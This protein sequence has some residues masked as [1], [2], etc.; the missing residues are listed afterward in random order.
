MNK[1]HKILLFLSFAI[2]FGTA[3]AVV[4]IAPSSPD[5]Q[6]SPQDEA[7]EAE[8]REPSF[9]V[10]NNKL[11]TYE[12]LGQT[13]SMDL[14]DPE[15]IKE[16]I[17]FDPLTNT[18]FFKTKVGN[19]DVVTPY[20]MTRDEYMDFSMK[21]SMRSYWAERNRA[22]TEND[23]KKE[24]SISD[25]KFNIGAADKIFGPGGV[26]VK[27]QG[28]TELLFGFKVN[29]IQNPTLSE[30][31]RNPSPIFDFDEKIQLNVNGKV[32]DKLNFTMN[33]NTEASF[34]YDQSK[35]KLAYEGK[36]DDIVQRV[37]AGNVSLPLN[38]ALIRG[39]SALF[40]IKTEL[41]FGK[42][43]VAAV[44]S[45]QETETKTVSL[46][47][48]AQTSKFELDA[49]QY[50]ENRH[51]FLGHYFKDN[52][53]K[54]MSRLPN[55]NSGI[56]VNRIEVWITNK[57]ADFT[58]ARNIV[59][60]MDLGEVSPNIDNTNLWTGTAG[61]LLPY[62]KAN[63]LYRD[64]TSL[65]NVRD[66]QQVNTV[67]ES[68]FPSVSTGFAGGEDFEKVES[69]RLLNPNEFTLNAQLGYLS[70]KSQLNTD[71][72]L[73]VAYEYTANGKVYQVGE[74]SSDGIE[75]PNAL[76]LKMLKGTAFSPSEKNWSLMMK[77]VYSLGA[78]QIQSE[79]FKLDV[80]FQN[81]STGAYVNYMPEGAMRNQSLL[82]V[83]KLD[84]LDRRNQLRP[85][86]FFDY[87]DGFTIIPL[88]GRIIFPVLE[89]FGSSLRKS[90]GNDVI[91]QKYIFQE[92]YDSTKIVAEELSEKNKFVLRG[93]Y[94]ASVN[95]EIRLNAM[96]VPQGSVTVL[97]GGV[98]L[99]E[100]IDYTV[101]YSMG[102]VTILNQ[103]IL[104]SGT[105]IDVSLESQ[106]F[107]SMQR[108]T[109]TGV[110][111]EYQFNKNFS[112]GGTFMH[113]SEKPLTNKVAFGDE[114]MSNTI[115]GLNTDF[116][117]ES[118]FITNLV[119]KI[120][121]IKATAPSSY[122]LS[123]E[124]AQLIP[125]HPNVIGSEGLSYLDDFEAS[126]TSINIQYP[127]AWY[128]ASTPKKPTMFPEATQT[129]NVDYGKNRALISWFTIDPLF[130]TNTST[131][132]SH[133]R[134]DKE[135]LSNHFVRS[136]EEQE[137]FPNREP[138]Q[139]QS[140]TLSVLNL[141]YYPTQRGPYN[142]DADNINPDGSLK[143]PEKRWAGIMRKMEVA[144][145]ESANIEY[146]EF[147]ML[148]PFVYDKNAKG[149]DLYLNLGEI[150]EDVL[151]DGKK[152]F[153]NGLAA[154]GDTTQTTRTVWGRVP[155]TQSM[156]NAF[157]NE[158][159]A[160]QYQDVGMDGLRT[161]DE[162]SFSSYKNYLD[163]F[164]LKV[165]PGKLDSLQNDPFSPIN[166]P[167]GDNYRYYRGSDADNQNM[168]ILD[169]YK[170]YNGQE[171]NSPVTTSTSESYTT[172]ATNLPNL[173]DIN[174]DNNLNEYE[175]FWEYRV[176]IKP[177]D[178]VVGKNYISDKVVSNV[179]LE[180]GNYEEVAWYQF[181]VPVHEYES[182]FGM[183]D[184]RSIRFMRMYM[185][186]FE[187]TTNLRFGTMELVRGDWRK[188]KKPLY[189]PLSPPAVD[190]TLEVAVVNIEENADK[191]PVNYVLP[192]GVEREQDPSQSQIRQE[193]EQS[194]LLKVTNLAPK[195][196][197]GVYKTTTYDMRQFKR[198][199]MYV[200]AEEF[201]DDVT[202][203]E[204]SELT[205]FVRVGSDLT[206]NYYEY[207]IPLKLTSPGVYSETESSGDREKVWPSEN[208][209][210][211]NLESL[212]NVKSNR[213]KE[214]R[215]SGS[216]I[217][218]T[219]AYSEY[220]PD[221]PRNKITVVGNPNL[222]DV[223][224]IMVGVRN[225]SSQPKSGEIWVNELR[226]SGFNEE[227]GYAALANATVNLS[228][229][230]SVNVGGRVETIGFGGIEDNVMERRM[231]D[232][233]QFNVSTNFELGRFFPE[234]AK[235]RI[236]MYYSYSQEV[237]KPKYDAF[238]QDILLSKTLEDA[239]TK[240]EE[241]SISD[242]SNTVYTTRS[243]NF[244][245]VRV[246]LKSKTPM[247]YDP[248][249][250]SLN[251]SYTESYLHSPE[252]ER[253]V[254]KDYKAGINYIYT[255]SPRPW[256]PFKNNK[257]L[258]KPTMR[259]I[260][261]F[262][263]F[264]LPVSIA[265]STSMMRQYNEKQLRNLD[266]P[267][268][269]YTDPN[270]PLLSNSKDFLWNRKF[271]FKYDFSRALKFSYSNSINSQI[272]ESRYAPVNKELFPD[273]YQNW[274]D[275]VLRSIGNGGV[276]LA[277]QQMVTGSYA[278]PIN[279]IPALSWINSNVMY[280]GNYTWDRGALTAEDDEIG[281][282]T[283][284]LGNNI[285][286][287]G[288]WQFD[289]R[290]SLDQLY[291]KSSYL[292][293]VNKRFDTKRTSKKETETSVKKKVDLFEQKVKLVKGKSQKLS[294]RL[295]V[296]KIRLFAFDSVGNEYK[297]KYTS[298]DKNTIEINP[299]DGKEITV[300]IQALYP[301]EAT[302]FEYALQ[303]S[304]RVLMMIRNLSFNYNQSNGMALAGFIPASGPLGQDALGSG[305]APGL[306]FAMG[307]Q[308]PG[309][310]ETAY[311]KDWLLKSDSTISG[312]NKTFTS[313]LSIK[314]KVEPFAGLKIDF[315]VQRSYATQQ[316][317][318]YMYAGMPSTM[319]GSFSMT[320]IGIGTFFNSIGNSSNNYYSKSYESFKSNR[321][322]TQ[323]LLESRYAGRL[324]PKVGFMTSA[325][326]SLWAGQEYNSS[327]VGGFSQ[328]SAEVLVPSFLS[329]YTG[330]DLNSNNLDLIPSLL[331][332]LPN[333]RITYDGLSRISF[334]QDYVKSVNLTHAYTC[335]YNVGAFSSYGNWIAMDGGFGF[336]EDVSSGLP[337]PSSQFDVPAVSITENFNP[338]LRVDVTLKNNI[339]L[340]TEYSKGRVLGLNIASTQ[341]VE[342]G[343]DTY[344]VGA[345]Y[346]LSD[347]DVILRLSNDKESK[348]KNDLTLRADFSW[349]DTK[350]LIRKLDDD[351]ATQATSGDKT[352]GVQCSAEYVF[353]SKMNFRLYYDR[354]VSTPLI[355]SS[356]PTSSSSFGL[357]V[358]LLL[359]R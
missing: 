230:G 2:L 68:A 142:L 317:I 178:M 253:D 62:N 258:R 193:N 231:D 30:R 256:E 79:N 291:N 69:A 86:G 185:T 96:N 336:V 301:E 66:I 302:G 15:N 78:S 115:W 348:V 308:E 133:I 295:N 255:L 264:Y 249:N 238:N 6:F 21:Q 208:M 304:S 261:D 137:I 353:S 9:S 347:F 167:A 252:V 268:I 292:R 265:Y 40:G 80:M 349:K 153:E 54:S 60:F 166:D 217:T 335:K 270:N 53:E 214:K 131:T 219:T 38:S 331:R 289:G 94:K 327:A 246:D 82:K 346:K 20:S 121:L 161:E 204:N 267:E 85:D 52:F 184:F 280:T 235:V 97:A 260:G 273:E 67:L 24:F 105:S 19:M 176:S 321:A 288:S 338:L 269:S 1:L 228:D 236:P 325:E 106:S 33:Y 313:D 49:D 81:D 14:K 7:G 64:V 186:G 5:T 170:Y 187:N 310:L 41:K 207:S 216:Q 202:A 183:R 39:S 194:M 243:F 123:G 90:I 212:T 87:V 358:K 158:E 318:Q 135:Q 257:F 108:K 165:D 220:D 110:H 307:Y 83:L 324:Y 13:H 213:N 160:R 57:R 240:Q 18:Y 263:V 113:L 46:K 119:D 32:G 351:N 28:S 191:K 196:A 103:A 71:E 279:K 200:H 55:I 16:V 117:Q 345:G 205:A 152:S 355:S 164:R 215:K 359:T 101:D 232:F 223:Q 76:M 130:T 168:S 330:M 199:Q 300:K 44:A 47:N 144:D 224:T 175:K 311:N 305:S 198:L 210:D 127:Y 274:K 350:A 73:A 95:S 147:W 319:T 282:K 63:N 111:L 114:P 283:S 180:N 140:N 285:T 197:R 155:T 297:L 312:A 10:K 70:L 59:A 356:F 272:E 306:L 77:N 104:E 98:K 92:L 109:L 141:S 218:F 116:K 286:S 284:S 182:N 233:T 149:G 138:I 129:N 43:S 126:K 34:D 173:E 12:D 222:G 209:F 107:F 206:E 227:G 29:R 51:Y 211:F 146:V 293:M 298:I 226:L 303:A 148:D 244:T 245:N 354:Q 237:S 323:A 333:W 316:Q 248:A 250:F 11:D 26:Q 72:V 25:M 125:G 22:E 329:A 143:N 75:A 112:L 181:K 61:E 154:S 56:V 136:V 281:R 139:G 124:F 290:F 128:L 58:Q 145:F 254:T 251:Y 118:Q 344:V 23:K 179:K 357:S 192:P 65:L 203:L 262:N 36:E 334:I 320:T 195:D 190:G 322:T 259:I 294:H 89:P 340:S 271:D 8:G 229:V 48:G 275:T 159:S 315:G 177:A 343:N 122:K 172:S 102:S 150:S 134:N 100:N 337:M 341:L 276:P 37:E 242:Y 277:F 221:K 50:D 132:P 266:N 328:N 151:K 157:D 162:L 174:Q 74:F 17:E 31:L 3:Y 247:F 342:S 93:E 332:M 314:M 287:L 120:P 45:Q 188:V 225:Q 309:F 4:N 296:E 278:L 99:T 88:T 42:L 239:E 234:N 201:I 35:I 352:L 299:K 189:D 27:M 84:R 241:D 156:V 326:A 91:A 171:G 163:N 169:R 339:T